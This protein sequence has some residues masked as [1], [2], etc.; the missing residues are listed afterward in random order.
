MTW[1]SCGAQTAH[2]LPIDD[3]KGGLG[4]LFL[5]QGAVARAQ[6]QLGKPGA[7]QQ[8][9]QIGDGIFPQV[10]VRQCLHGRKKRQ[11]LCPGL[12]QIDTAQG[13]KAGLLARLADNEDVET[14]KTTREERRV[15]LSGSLLYI[16]ATVFLAVISGLYLEMSTSE[17]V[18]WVLYTA[19]TTV[20]AELLIGNAAMNAG[21]FPSSAIAMLFV[22]IG[23]LLGFDVK[24]LIFLAGF[25]TCG[26]PAFAD[27]G[28]DLKTGWILRG[29]GRHKEF[30]MEGRRQ[31]LYAEII[32]LV[33][34][35]AMA[36]LMHAN[37]FMK[38]LIPPIARVFATTIEAGSNPEIIRAL[39]TWSIAGAVIQFFG[40][41][42]RQM[43]V[44][45][46]TGLL[47]INATGGFA[48]YAALAI[49]WVLHKIYKGKEDHILYITAAGFIAGASLFSF[50]KGTL[51]AFGTKK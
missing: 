27:M 7:L 43:G 16:L 1:I 25:K 42:H 17:L 13:R 51:G 35:I 15:L 2:L 19:L 44:L 40:G 31:Q 6:Y 24:A 29:E 11:I 3:L 37:Y 21:W 36:V 9:R 4:Q 10:Q 20:A 33:I 28:Y 48:V 38:D 32:G 14:F 39:L 50:F 26:G 8:R 41:P 30:E 5:G 47:M 12:P 49:R 46:G 23:L 18:L 45:F 22:I 34:G